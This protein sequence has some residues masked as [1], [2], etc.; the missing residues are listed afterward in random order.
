MVVVEV[1]YSQQY[2]LPTRMQA[3]GPLPLAATL[4]LKLL[5]FARR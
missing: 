3:A 4:D 2:Q 1:D 5:V